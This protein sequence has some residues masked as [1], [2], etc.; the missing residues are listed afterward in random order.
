LKDGER[1]SRINSQSGQGY[2]LPYEACLVYGEEGR[3]W[4]NQ[5]GKNFI[6]R[7]IAQEMREQGVSFSG[8]AG[9]GPSML[10]SY[11]KKKEHDGREGGRNR[12]Q[13]HKS[14]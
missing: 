5:K 14:G 12:L 8:V 3:Q 2:Q 9:G 6:D 1:R 4:E 7:G 11:L 13:F 10:I